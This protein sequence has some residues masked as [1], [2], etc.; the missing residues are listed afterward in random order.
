MAGDFV[1]G[2]DVDLGVG[3]VVGKSVGR[4]VVS[5]I[6][7]GVGTLVEDFVGYLYMENIDMCHA[8]CVRCVEN[9]EKNTPR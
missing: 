7:G 8:L 3:L 5:S 1:I 6:D 9:G 4:S 2:A